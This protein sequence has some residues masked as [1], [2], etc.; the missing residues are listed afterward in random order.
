MGY[1]GGFIPGTTVLGYMSRLMQE[2]YGPRW[3][4]G[5]TFNGRLRRPLYEGQPA[6]VT[7]AVIEDATEANGNTVTVE[8]KVIDG[9]GT[10][11]AFAEATCKV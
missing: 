11:V 8:L 6:T 7:G 4:S 2:A 10:V 3:Q 5:S 1:R 9:E